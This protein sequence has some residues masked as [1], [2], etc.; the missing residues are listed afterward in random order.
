[1]ENT[2]LWTQISFILKECVICGTC[3]SMKYKR[4]LHN[5]L[6]CG[7][8]FEEAI[9]CCLIAATNSN[10]NTSLREQWIRLNDEWKLK[11][12]LASRRDCGLVCVFVCEAEK[13]RATGRVCVAHFSKMR[14][15]N[16][17]WLFYS[18]R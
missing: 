5:G 9:L 18:P 12:Q 1:M 16:K 11:Y 8:T 4:I 17:C 2:Q 6:L 15:M 14:T 3:Q 10:L 13:D 7:R